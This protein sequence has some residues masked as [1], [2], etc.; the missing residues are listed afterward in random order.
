MAQKK[1]SEPSGLTRW[2]ERTKCS[3]PDGDQHRMRRE[4]EGVERVVEDAAH[5]GVFLGGGLGVQLL[6]DALL[7]VGLGDDHLDPGR[8]VIVGAEGLERQV[9]R[10]Q[11]QHRGVGIGLAR[12]G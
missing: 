2:I 11:R 9:G 12:R 10:R 7:D 5:P 1:L 8:L 6:D 3:P 4:G